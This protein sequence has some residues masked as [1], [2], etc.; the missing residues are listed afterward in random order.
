MTPQNNATSEAAIRGAGKV[1]IYYAKEGV[2]EILNQ[3]SIAEIIQHAIDEHENQR[4]KEL[5]QKNKEFMGRFEDNALA[6]LESDNVCD[7]AGCPTKIE[8]TH[9]T[10]WGR[11]GWLAKE[12][13]QAQQV[14]AGMRDNI[15]KAITHLKTYEPISGSSVCTA[16]EFLSNAL[17][18][19]TGKGWVRVEEVIPLIVA[20][21]NYLYSPTISFATLQA[22]KNELLK[23][24]TELSAMLKKEES[25]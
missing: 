15:L 25:E 14:V 20:A 6:W 16:L 23:R 1:M 7:K 8:N 4:I 9:L 21:E 2:I 24:L 17:S 12:R 3:Y 18:S 19:S 5:E 22:R 10:I 13:D 11:I